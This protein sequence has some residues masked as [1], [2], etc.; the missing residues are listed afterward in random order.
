MSRPRFRGA[1]T[2]AR[3]GRAVSLNMPR[4]GATPPGGRQSSRALKVPHHVRRAHGDGFYC[5]RHWPVWTRSAVADGS[6]PGSAP[7]GSPRPAAVRRAGPPYL[8]SPG[9]GRTTS[10]ALRHDDGGV[11]RTGTVAAMSVRSRNR[12]ARGRRLVVCQTNARDRS[13]VEHELAL[14][15]GFLSPSPDATDGAACA[16]RRGAGAIS[17]DCG[18]GA[19]LLRALP[20]RPGGRVPIWFDHPRVLALF[21]RARTQRRD[22]RLEDDDADGTQLGSA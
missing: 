10:K 17:F 4:H 12:R 6:H 7:T 20:H 21:L 8:G 14:R 22:G 18:A 13:R 11:P 3:G 19:K 1:R 2:A 9:C 15:P 16:T 5:R